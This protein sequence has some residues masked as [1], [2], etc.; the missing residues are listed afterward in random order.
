MI[1]CLMF[2]YKIT[3]SVSVW[4]V[5]GLRVWGSYVPVVSSK[6]VWGVCP[7]YEGCVRVCVCACVR[8]C[9]V[10]GSQRTQVAPCR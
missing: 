6:C 10:D 9:V 2:A 3:V 4:Y 7:W 1:S 5:H 8:V